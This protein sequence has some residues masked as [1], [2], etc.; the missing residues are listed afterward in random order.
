MIRN[1]RFIPLLTSPAGDEDP[2]EVWTWVLLTGGDMLFSRQFL[3]ILNNP[4]EV[5]GSKGILR[6]REIAVAWANT[7]RISPEDMTWVN[8]RIV[9]HRTMV[10]ESSV[11]ALPQTE[12]DFAGSRPEL[13]KITASSFA[14]FLAEV[15]DS[16]SS[17]P[18]RLT[19]K[20]CKSC[21][22]LFLQGETGREKE[23]CSSRCK[24]RLRRM[25]LREAEGARERKTSGR[26]GGKGT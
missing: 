19:L 9:P 17:G 12:V 25:A 16:R 26:P 1:L 8:A 6:M 18:G 13:E 14:E 4:V 7:G 5:Q 11:P 21:E 20:V 2:G 23:V 3:A 10:R 15:A 22:N 24:F